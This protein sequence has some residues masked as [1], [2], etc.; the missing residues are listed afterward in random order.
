MVLAYPGSGNIDEDIRDKIDDFVE[1]QNDT[2]EL[3]FFRCIAQKELFHHLAREAAP[4]Q[5]DLQVRLTHYGNVDQPLKAVYGQIS[6]SDV[7]KWYSDHGNNLFSG[8]IRHFLGERSDVN[9]GIADTLQNSP[10]NFW[11]FNNGITLIAEGFKRQAIGSADKSVGIFECKGV[12][13]VNGAQ[14]VGIRW[15]A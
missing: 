1:S 12:T 4:S 15:S 2:S 7:A 6:A 10:D 13:I 8:N 11:Y 14:T 9:N 3:F 5:I